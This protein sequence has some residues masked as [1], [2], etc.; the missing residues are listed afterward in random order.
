[1]GP[2]T[3]EPNPALCGDPAGGP[4]LSL[5]LISKDASAVLAWPIDQEISTRPVVLDRAPYLPA[6]VA[7]SCKAMPR[8]CAADADTTRG[9]P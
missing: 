7:S 6:F 1:M 4:P 9:A 5:Q 8:A 3:V 2:I